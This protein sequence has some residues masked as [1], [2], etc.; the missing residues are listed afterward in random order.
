MSSKLTITVG[1]KTNTQNSL[2]KESQKQTLSPVEERVIKMIKEEIANLPPD[3][4][5]GL[6][7]SL[8]KGVGKLAKSKTV[9]KM[10]SQLVS[11][12]KEKLKDP[13]FREF[14]KQKATALADSYEKKAAAEAEAKGEEVPPNLKQLAM[15]AAAKAVKNPKYQE[16]ALAALDKKA[17]SIPSAQPATATATE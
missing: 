16:K 6:F 9:R 7:G 4:Q 1:T 8:A 15:A 17:A 12:A 14:L 3:V 10:G 13:K 5:E 11:K 2:M